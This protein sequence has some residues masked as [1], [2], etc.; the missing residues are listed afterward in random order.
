MILCGVQGLFQGCV[1]DCLDAANHSG[2]IGMQTFDEERVF[3]YLLN[4]W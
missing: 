4:D 2:R 3:K 1:D